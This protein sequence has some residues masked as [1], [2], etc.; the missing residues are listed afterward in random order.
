MWAFRLSRVSKGSFNDAVDVKPYKE[1]AV[2][3]KND[4]I[5]ANAMLSEE[6]LLGDEMNILEA[7]SG[8]GDKPEQLFFVKYR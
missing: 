8:E 1:G 7:Y 2:L 4:K 5:S 6:G 3:A